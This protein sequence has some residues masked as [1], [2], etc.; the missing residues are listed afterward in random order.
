MLGCGHEIATN[1]NTLFGH[2][3]TRYHPIRAPKSWPITWHLLSLSTPNKAKNM[4][5]S[6]TRFCTLYAFRADGLSESPKPFRSTAITLK[7]KQS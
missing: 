2:K 4:A 7:H 5:N 6:F 3:C 1:F